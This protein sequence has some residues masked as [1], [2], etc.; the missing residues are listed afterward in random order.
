[1]RSVKR[2]L[3]LIRHGQYTNESSGKPDNTRTLTP[4]GVEQA[5]LTGEFLR[6][7]IF[8]GES[9]LF[10]EKTVN[11][12]M[13]SNLTRAVQTTEH[14]ISALDPNLKQ[15]WSQDS[16]LAERLVCNPSPP[17]SKR[18]RPED[19]K[20]VEGAFRKY[21]VRPKAGSQTSV[22]VIVCHGN[23]IRYFLCRALQLP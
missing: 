5:K 8:G 1:S 12:I 10:A 20:I 14:I 4:T 7:T 13:S 15:L 11:C 22:E 2:Q 6:K 19:H 16:G 3:L 23:V 17:L 9:E 21:V 18:A